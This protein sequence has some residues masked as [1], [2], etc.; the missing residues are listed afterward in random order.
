VATR[1]PQFGQNE[2]PV[3][4]GEPQLVQKRPD[5]EAGGCPA[6]RGAGAGGPAGGGGAYGGYPYG[7]RYPGYIIGRDFVTCPPSATMRMTPTIMSGMPMQRNGKNRIP[8][9]DKATPMTRSSAPVV[10]SASRACLP[11]IRRIRA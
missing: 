7:A 4:T 3:A 11:S 5:P 10:S 1:V 9:T 6:S 8:I 2:I